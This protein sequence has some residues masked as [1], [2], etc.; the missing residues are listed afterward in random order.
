[1]KIELRILNKEFYPEIGI[2]NEF[3]NSLYG[4]V[5]YSGYPGL[6]GYNTEGS[7]GIDLIATTD[8]TI[9]PGE[10]VAIPT[11]LAIHIGSGNINHSLYCT[12][13]GE[14]QCEIDSLD[15]VTF[16]GMI[17]PRSG[18]GTKG[19]ILANTIG[20]IDEDYQGEIIVQAWNRNPSSKFFEC[21]GLKGIEDNNEVCIEIKAGDR[22]AQL[23][24]VPIIKTQ[25]QVVDEFTT[26][27][28]RGI[29]GFGSTG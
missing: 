13:V 17:V 15:N 4:A 24:F 6:P 8:Y 10:T 7:A 29:D 26:K 21:A 3:R 25:W 23:I 9:Y 16:M 28:E 11:G 1:M 12:D 2:K 5:K 19:L 18:L 14:Q 20:I 27:T 22:F